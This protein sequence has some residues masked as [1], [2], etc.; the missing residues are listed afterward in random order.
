MKKD[1]PED[2][3]IGKLIETIS[4]LQRQIEVLSIKLYNLDVKV[5]N[6]WHIAKGQTSP[7]YLRE[8]KDEPKL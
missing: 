3:L 5:D 7:I 1:S 2:I 8:P 6:N 4:L